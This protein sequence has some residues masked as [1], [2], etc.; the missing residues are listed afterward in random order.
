M[1]GIWMP[2]FNVNVGTE[3]MV[4]LRGSEVVRI[5]RECLSL[6]RAERGIYNATDPDSVDL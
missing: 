2:L 5:P 4:R 3:D 1:L 6:T